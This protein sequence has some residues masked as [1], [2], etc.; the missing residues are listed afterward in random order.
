MVTS[1][2]KV[3]IEAVASAGALVADATVRACSRLSVHVSW[4][5]ILAAYLAIEIS[6]CHIGLHHVEF[7]LTTVLAKCSRLE[8][9]QRLF[10]SVV[11]IGELDIDLGFFRISFHIEVNLYLGN[12]EI[13]ECFKGILDRVSVLLCVQASHRS[14]INLDRAGIV[15]A[16]KLVS[17]TKLEKGCGHTA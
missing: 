8:N 16:S 5:Q 2:T 7:R 14:R 3:A 17:E 11:R 15:L 13:R 1:K 4:I 6:L 9:E 12:C 10:S